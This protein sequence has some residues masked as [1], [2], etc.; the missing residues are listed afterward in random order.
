MERAILRVTDRGA[1]STYQLA[2]L[3][4]PVLVSIPHAGRDLPAWIAAEARVAVPQL[5][6]LSDPWC[7]L[8]AAPL[9]AAGA[10]IVKANMLRAVVDCNRHEADMDPVDVTAALRPQFAPPDARPAQDLA[11]CRHAYRGAAS[12]GDRRSQVIISCEGSKDFIGHT[13]S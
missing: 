3:S 1:V 12:Y 8:I 6:R 4:L 10:R 5:H 7:D 13:T 2:G 11:W 9:L